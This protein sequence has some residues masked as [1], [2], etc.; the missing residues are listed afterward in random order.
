MI[1][2]LKHD[3]AFRCFC[4]ADEIRPCQADYSG[5]LCKPMCL[6]T[7]KNILHLS[8]S[9]ADVILCC[10]QAEP[11]H[12]LIGNSIVEFVSRYFSFQ[13]EPDC[14]AIVGSFAKT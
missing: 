11:N 14:Q 12:T 1:S 10:Q 4:F 9:A 2:D 6:Y 3:F 5:I 8:V 7:N 13:K